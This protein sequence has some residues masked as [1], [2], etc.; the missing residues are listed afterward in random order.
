MIGCSR[1]W[2]NTHVTYQS[3]QLIV[4]KKVNGN[5][6]TNLLI[7]HRNTWPAWEWLLY[8]FQTQTWILWSSIKIS[9]YGC[10]FC[11]ITNWWC[12][13]YTILN[14]RTKKRG[15]SIHL[16]IKRRTLLCYHLDVQLPCVTKVWLK[17]NLHVL[18]TLPTMA[19]NPPDRS[20]RTESSA[21]KNICFSLQ[22]KLC[23]WL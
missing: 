22:N 16:G 13:S 14:L 20:C 3:S 10:H 6:I 5:C 4:T 9:N 23:V 7:C 15:H 21:N 2:S 11:V 19:P 1:S 18:Y 17:A 8:L 12:S